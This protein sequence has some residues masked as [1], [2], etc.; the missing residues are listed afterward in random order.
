MAHPTEEEYREAYR[1]WL[2]QHPGK[3]GG[4]YSTKRSRRSKWKTN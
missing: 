2:Q 1:K 4:G 3:T